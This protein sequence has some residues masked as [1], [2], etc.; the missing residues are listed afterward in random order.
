MIEH[1]VEESTDE[2]IKKLFVEV[3]G[4][5][6][7][8]LADFL[9]ELD[10]VDEIEADMLSRQPR[11]AHPMGPN[12]HDGAQDIGGELG[13]EEG[14]RAG[15][16]N[17]ESIENVL[18]S[19]AARSMAEK[20]RYLKIFHKNTKDKSLWNVGIAHP[21]LKKDNSL[22]LIPINLSGKETTQQFTK[23]KSDFHQGRRHTT[24]AVCTVIPFAGLGDRVKER[25]LEC[26]DVV[27]RKL[28]QNENNDD[29]ESEASSEEEDGDLRPSEDY[30]QYSQSLN[31]NTLKSCRLCDFQT[32]DEYELK[33]H[34]EGHPKCSDCEMRLVDGRE[35]LIHREANH[36][37]FQCSVCNHE[38]PLTERV[39]HMRMH[40][41]NELYN[42][43]ITD[44]AKKTSSSKGW[45]LFLREKKALLRQVDPKLS[46]QLATSQVSALWK[47]LSKAE[48]KMWNLR[49][50]QEQT[51]ADE[52]LQ[53]AG[54][55][56]QE[57]IRR[58]V[59]EV[60]V[61]DQQ[62]PAERLQ[63]GGERQEEVR[64]NVVEDLVE[65]QQQPA[66][67]LHAVADGR[68]VEEGEEREGNNEL[69]Q[70]DLEDGLEERMLEE[71]ERN[72]AAVAL[73]ELL[74][75]VEI[76]LEDLIEE[77]AASSSLQVICIS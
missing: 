73:N 76:G 23:L 43:L 9:K 51:N 33:T 34:M 45:S 27:L 20:T 15:L 22:K 63:A 26:F 16:S 69:R 41:T 11:M 66:E 42:R 75:G 46:H 39:S 67:R 52:R 54:G 32:R 50:V 47:D 55:E 7:L 14:R 44:H 40:D 5:R 57:E 6:D 1:E 60:L 8:F 48:K 29:N 13:F 62:Q 24:A 72:E 19:I 77:S 59:V 4:D 3:Y 49:A 10:K 74:G 68:G 65:D 71:E 12:A 36:T 37:R 17:D 35:L 18:D 31:M 64:R 61:E 30:P 38:V 56:R 70:P 28:L 25:L 58:N 21:R 53:E 2:Q